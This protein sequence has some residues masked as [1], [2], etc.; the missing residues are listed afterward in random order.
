MKWYLNQKYIFFIKKKNIFI[1]K[2]KKNNNIYIYSLKL[3]K[4]KKFYIKKENI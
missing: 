2:K 1:N 3:I 4:S